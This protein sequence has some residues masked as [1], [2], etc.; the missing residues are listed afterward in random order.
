MALYYYRKWHFI[1]IFAGIFFEQAAD[2]M[3]IM[4]EEEKEIEGISS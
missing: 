3:Q 4:K 1:I 2:V